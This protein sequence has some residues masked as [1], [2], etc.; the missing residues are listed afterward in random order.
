M[1]SRERMATAMGH[2]VPDRVPVMCQLALGHY[3][4]R[5]GVS[6]I[7]IWHDTPA[8]GDVL[9][10][11]QRR[12]GFDGL[13]I[14]LPGRDPDWRGHIERIEDV[15]AD[16]HI[17]WENGLVTICP[18]DD[19]PHVYQSDRVTRR[20]P[21]FEE[22]DP[23]RLYYVEPH[24]IAGLSYPT[25]WGFG[26]R[27]AARPDFFPPWQYDTIRYVRARAPD[28]SVH[29]EVWS[30]FSQLM[31]LL[32]YGS[33]LMALLDDPGKVSACL[34]ALADGTIEL[35]RGQARAGAD[36]ILISSAFAGAGFISCEHYR[37]FVLP[38]ERKI[39][40][41]FKEA[42]PDVPVYTHTC[43]AIGDRLELLQA[44]GTDG[45]DTLDPPP[46][47]DVELA[48]AKQR[49]GR[50]LFIKGNMDPVNTLLDGT[51]D[52]VMEDARRR[53]EAGKPGGGY[54]LST[55]CS[56]SPATPPEN[57]LQLRAAVERYGRREVH[58]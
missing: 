28:V 36:A 33:A 17:V 58:P 55:A 6:P 42:Y 32:D 24:D 31:D 44:T 38:C 1:T 56:V 18:P 47:G 35:M 41:G 27:K 54:I 40:A 4:L 51:P 16:Q 10:A 22:I 43:G 52:E 39:I 34:D 29:A 2:G 30:P 45:I 48:D 21:T 37:Q 57:I 53:I 20:I 25:R 12:Y 26:S 19:N 13:L 23:A 8:F 5:T 3:F 49:V 50:R 7:E 11:L 14:N 15:G 9:L 46:L